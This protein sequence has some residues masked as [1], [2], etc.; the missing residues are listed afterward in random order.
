MEAGVSEIFQP[1]RLFQ[2]PLSRSVDTKSRP[3]PHHPEKYPDNTNTVPRVFCPQH[4]RLFPSHGVCHRAELGGV[5]FVIDCQ[6]PSALV[7]GIVEIKDIPV[8]VLDASM[9]P[10]SRFLLE[11]AQTHPNIPSLD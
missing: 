4:K 9:P 5:L 1:L 7:K 3:R 11:S 2:F 8:I 10:A 6:D